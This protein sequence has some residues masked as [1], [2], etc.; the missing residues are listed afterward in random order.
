[1]ILFKNLKA[2]AEASSFTLNHYKRNVHKMQ[3]TRSELSE[4]NDAFQILDNS[5]SE[6]FYEIDKL[7]RHAIFRRNHDNL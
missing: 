4:I 1:M 2:A 3:I 6:M 5:V 7:N